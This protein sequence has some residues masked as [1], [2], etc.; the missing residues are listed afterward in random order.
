MFAV[1]YCALGVIAWRRPLLARMALRETV[2]RPWQSVL[3]VAGLTVGT[4]MILMSLV[5]TDS[6][7]TTLTRATYQSWGRVDLLVSANGAFFS[8]DVAK[9]LGESPNLK[10]KVRA[11]Q[12]G[13]ELVGTVADLNQWLNN[14]TVRLIGFDPAAQS[15][16]GPYTLGDGNTTLGQDLGPGDVLLSQSLATSIQAQTGDVLQVASSGFVPVEGGRNRPR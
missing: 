8:P 5:D 9:G 2:R 4:S 3:V 10:G 15:S 16:F 7:A 14:P 13:V 11:V 6:I 1:V 12:A